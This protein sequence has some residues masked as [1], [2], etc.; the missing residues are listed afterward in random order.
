MSSIFIQCFAIIVGEEG[1]WDQDPRDSGNWTSGTIGVGTCAGTKYGVSAAA[2][3]TLNIGALTLADAQGIYYRDY[4]TKIA[5]DALPPDIA[6]YTFDA[7]VNS[8]WRRG[9]MWLQTAL[10]VTPDGLI[11]EKTIS[12]L[13]G[14]NDNAALV[15][16]LLG[17][18][19]VFMSDTPV[20]KTYRGGWTTRVCALPVR[21][22]LL[23]TA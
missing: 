7:A 5:G 8:G 1:G 10:G 23:K 17:T 16:T 4:W 9:A 14:V 2:Y 13:R 22:Q 11:G 19:I 20:W 3:P 12:A 15:G 6:L 21:A 18:R